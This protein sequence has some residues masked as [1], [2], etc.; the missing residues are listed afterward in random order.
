MRVFT[1]RRMH[2]VDAH[3]VPR[4]LDR[5]GLGHAGDRVLGG[6]VGQHVGRAVQASHRRGVDHA[7]GAGLVHVRQYVLHA[8]EGA[9]DVDRDH[10]VE[11]GGV[12]LF[13]GRD[14]A[15]DAGVV[16]EHVD[17]AERVDRRLHVGGD[18]L[19]LADVGPGDGD[20]AAATQRVARGVQALL[21]DIHQQ[22]RR[23]FLEEAFGDL[24]ADATG[25]A[26]DHRDLVLQAFH[27]NLP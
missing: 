6:D 12:L 1:G 24:L 2:R 23:A 13:Q 21:V 7:A 3:A 9:A 15:L 19:L 22:H 14:L 11:H 8:E 5:R 26:G 25:P 16:E 17:A 20:A 27:G 18:V 4:G 10:L